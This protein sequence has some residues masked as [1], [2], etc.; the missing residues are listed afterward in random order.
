MPEST[1]SAP[2]LGKRFEEA[3]EYATRV[4]A[5]QTRKGTAIPYVAHLLGAA[6]LV[7]EDGGDENQA[8]AA[9]LHDAVEDQGGAPR[10]ADIRARFGDDVA[11]IV[12]ACS[13]ADTIPKPPWQ[14]RKDIY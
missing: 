8:I 5:L 2:I 13:D 1:A 9:L 3:L 12:K 11:R 4:H 10:L 6:S 7:L 14:E